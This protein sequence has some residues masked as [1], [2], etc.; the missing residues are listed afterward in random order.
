MVFDT[1]HLQVVTPDRRLMDQVVDEVQLPGLEGYLGILPGH[2]PLFTELGIG[3]LSCRTGKELHYA[4]IIGG[5]AEVLPDHVTVL[6]ERAERAEE[7]DLDRAR[8]AQERAEKR[9]ARP[10]DPEIDWNRATAALKRAMVRLQV[11]AKGGAVAAAN[12][13]SRAVP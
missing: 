11:A 12:E 6:A 9:I 5:Y 2:A 8:A 4:T 3:E 7:I 13:S 10:G 1:L